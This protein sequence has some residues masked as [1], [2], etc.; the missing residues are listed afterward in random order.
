MSNGILQ[1]GYSCQAA[2]II[3]S[4]SGTL[5]RVQFFRHCKP[6]AKFD[7]LHLIDVI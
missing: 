5:E 3:S 6:L 1:K 7:V 2:K 4:S